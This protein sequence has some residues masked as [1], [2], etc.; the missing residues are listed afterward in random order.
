M[1]IFICQNME[2]QMAIRKTLFT[3]NMFKK[4]AAVF[5][6]VIVTPA[7][8]YAEEDIYFTLSYGAGLVETEEYASE[9]AQIIADTLGQSVLYSYE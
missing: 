8:V 3:K 1:F 7:S 2:N 9:T 6:S 5:L 4:L